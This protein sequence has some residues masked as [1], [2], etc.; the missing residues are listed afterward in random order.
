M[1]IKHGNDLLIQMITPKKSE[2][3]EKFSRGDGLNREDIK[4]LFLKSQNIDIKHLKQQL[5]KVTS[6]VS[7][8]RKQ[9]TGIENKVELL[10]TNFRRDKSEFSINI[11]NSNKEIKKSIENT[12][13]WYLGI[14][15]VTLILL[16]ILEL[17][18][19]S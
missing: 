4:T 2:I 13:R 11:P 6:K 9:V 8:L 7:I 15:G 14:I 5:D 1:N 18:I 16:E 19:K 3:E 10:Q 17:Y 12:M